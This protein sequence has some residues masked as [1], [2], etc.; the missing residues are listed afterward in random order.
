MAVEG[1]VVDQAGDLPVP[2]EG[3]LQEHDRCGAD[4]GLQPEG[5]H[6]GCAECHGRRDPSES[7]HAR[8]ADGS[9]HHE[10]GGKS[11]WPQERPD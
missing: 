10:D 5:L 1:G 11:R 4:G 6:R 3:A 7:G 8:V 2:G 9:R